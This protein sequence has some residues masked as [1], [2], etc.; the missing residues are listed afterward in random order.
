MRRTLLVIAEYRERS[1]FRVLACSG[2]YYFAD[3]QGR[4]V[5]P[6]RYLSGMAVDIYFCPC[7]DARASESAWAEPF[8][9]NSERAEIYFADM[10]KTFGR[11]SGGHIC[12]GYF[13]EM[14]GTEC[15]AAGNYG[16]FSGPRAYRK[17]TTGDNEGG[18]LW[19]DPFMQKNFRAYG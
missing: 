2:L 14:A 19:V 6:A 16:A 9:R 15:G 12:I 18:I 4:V 3:K 1:V 13:A 17:I 11:N 5:R 7:R 10:G 8:H